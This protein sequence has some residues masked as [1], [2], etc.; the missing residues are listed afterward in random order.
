MSAV[1]DIRSYIEPSSVPVVVFVDLQQEY[2]SS[3]AFALPTAS[4]ALISC[5]RVLGH[6]RAIGLPVAFVRYVTHSPFFNRAT[7]FC[8]WIDGFEPTSSDMVFERSRPSC[9]SSN[10]FE[11]VIASSGGNII[12]AGFAGETACLSTAVDAFNR[13][14][15]VTFLS[16]ASAS[17]DIGGLA[18]TD[19]HLFLSRIMSLYGKVL[20]T[21]EWISATSKGDTWKPVNAGPIQNRTAS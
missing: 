21:E 13:E 8:R 15:R 5:Q 6:A 7:Q 20:S 11:E 3:R 2:T 19:V 17:H 16:D 9:Y 12:L 14:H 18:A 10:H 4:E 1:I